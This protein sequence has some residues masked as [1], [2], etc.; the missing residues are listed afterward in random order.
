MRAAVVYL[1]GLT[2]ATRF[3]WNRFWFTPADPATLAGIRILAGAMLFYT[4]AI[5]TIDLE[6][7]FG[8]D[9]R[10]SWEFNETFHESPAAWS[11]FHVVH[12]PL[13]LWC[14]HIATLL[15]VGLLTIGWMTP[16]VSVLSF[17]LAASYAHRAAGALF[18]L[19]QINLMLALYLA[20]GD[21][22]GAYS[23]DARRRRT[24]V[25]T[26]RTNVAVRLMQLHLC[27]IY[28]FAAIGKLQGESWWTGLAMWL[29]M[30]NYEYQSIDMTGLAR[31]PMV[32]NFLT[33][34]SLLWELTYSVLVWP[35][36][37][38]P[39]VLALAVL[40]HGGIALCMGMIT[41]GLVML[42]ANLSFVPPDV[43]RT[44]VAAMAARTG[45]PSRRQRP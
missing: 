41:F 4:H 31:W 45:Q 17:F 15:V 23:L 16:V 21:S 2:E 40:L 33:H 7:F 5:W 19:D 22:G 32:I 38:R 37:T 29:A 28:F 14:F 20:V 30:A 12:S 44:C 6:G 9:S 10:L 27:V 35:R 26:V 25:P 13:V 43:I 11:M 18:G 3:G 34:V 36:W 1:R 42:I 8:T 24:I 39:L